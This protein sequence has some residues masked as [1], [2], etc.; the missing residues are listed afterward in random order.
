MKML[1]LSDIHANW[2]ALD[3]VSR[4]EGSWDELTFCGDAVDYGPHPV[5][6]VRWLQANARHAIRGNHDNALATSQDCHCMG[7]YRPYSLATRAWHRTLLGADDVEYLRHLFAVDLF[8]WCG[9]HFRVG[10]ATPAG[11]LFEYVSPDAWEDLVAGLAADFVLL[12]HTHV[13]GCGRSGGR[14]S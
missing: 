3:A 2:P 1:V 12:G 5:E 8:E 9:A 13:Q 6:C 4:A 14:R 11:G 10:H 7:P